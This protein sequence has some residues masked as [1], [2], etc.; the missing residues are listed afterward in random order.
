MLE[1]QLNGFNSEA[2]IYKQ[3]KLPL[4]EQC[5]I[6][7]ASKGNLSNMN[8]YFSSLNNWRTSTDNISNSNRDTF[9]KGSKISFSIQSSSQ[10][11][12]NHRHVSGI[13]QSYSF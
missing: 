2:L 4:G 11:K 1:W 8:K 7:D 13:F 5:L 3:S 6:T 9:L 10:Q 12:S